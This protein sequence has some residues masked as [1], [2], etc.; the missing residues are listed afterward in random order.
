M[1]FTLFPNAYPGECVG[2]LLDKVNEH[3]FY[4]LEYTKWWELDIREA[5]REQERTG[6]GIVSTCTKVFNLVDRRFAEE[7]K[8]ALRKTLETC[9][10]LGTPTIISQCG[11]ERSGVSR[12]EQRQAIV[13]TLKECAPL[14]EAAGVTLALEPLN[15]L[16]HPGHFLQRSDE[17]AGIVDAVGSPFVKFLFD[18]YHQQIT[19]GNLIARATAYMDRIRHFHIADNPGRHEPGTGE[20]NYVRILQALREAGYDGCVGLECKFSIDADEAITRFKQDIVSK[21]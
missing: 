10:I 1:K 5:A 20:L 6:V 18:F 12:E 19:E 16:N 13:D 9:A 11:S 8:A 17:A 7:Y 15:E 14:C 3:G 4:G 21:L 2:Y